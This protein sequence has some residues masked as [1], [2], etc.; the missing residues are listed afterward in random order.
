MEK[1]HLAEDDY[2]TTAEALSDALGS[3]CFID[4]DI[5]VLGDGWEGFLRLT[6]IIHRGVDD[7]PDYY[8]R[9]ITN[10]IPIWWEFHTVVDG[11]EILNDFQFGELKTYLIEK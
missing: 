11:E 10:V 4:D 9:P 2:R 1:L 7:A 8:R 5:E 6:A 3:A